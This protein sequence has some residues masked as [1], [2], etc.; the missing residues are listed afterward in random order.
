MFNPMTNLRASLVAY[1]HGEASQAVSPTA[2]EQIRSA[3][4]AAVKLQAE[5]RAALEIS[6]RRLTERFASAANT[7]GGDARFSFPFSGGKRCHLA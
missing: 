6:A 1:V 7:V 2:I 4:S 5:D 3:V